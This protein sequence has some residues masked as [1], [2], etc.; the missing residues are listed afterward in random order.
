MK[1]AVLKQTFLYLPQLI[2]SLKS[3]QILHFTGV[4][5]K[6]EKVFAMMAF[7][8]DSYIDIPLNSYFCWQL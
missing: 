3:K 6:N 5:N 1:C 4:L 7:K 8:P 2:F